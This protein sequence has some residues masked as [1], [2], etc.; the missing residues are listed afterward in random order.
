MES[1]ACASPD[2]KPSTIKQWSRSDPV[3]FVTTAVSELNGTSG[4]ATYGP[5]YN[6][7]D[8]GQHEWFIHLQKWLG[9]SHPVNTAQDFVLAPLR[10]IPNSPVLQGA[11]KTVETWFAEVVYEQSEWKRVEQELTS[12]AE[13]ASLCRKEFHSSGV[14]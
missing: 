1:A 2:E 4:T 9:V 13:S 6:H 7:N 3:D 12:Q 8:P 10:A 11:L 14:C 5:P